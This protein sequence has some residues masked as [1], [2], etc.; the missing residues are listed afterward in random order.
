MDLLRAFER[1]RDL[2]AWKA[3]AQEGEG[4]GEGTGTAT[5]R[6]FLQHTLQHAQAL[7][8]ASERVL[9]TARTHSD[10]VLE[11]VL[12]AAVHCLENGR[13]D[14][15]KLVLRPFP[16][17][18]PLAAVLAWDAVAVSADADVLPARKQ[19]LRLLAE[20]PTVQLDAFDP[21]MLEAC[22]ELQ[23]RLYVAERLAVESRDFQQASDREL[24]FASL[25][26]EKLSRD[27]PLKVLLTDLPNLP[28]GLDPR[29][30]SEVL[31]A[32]PTASP[33]AAHALAHDH[34]VLHVWSVLKGAIEN[35]TALPDD[36]PAGG[37]G[38]AGAAEPFFVGLSRHL[39]EIRCSFL[40][41]WTLNALVAFLNMDR[42]SKF[43]Q[44]GGT[45][46]T[47]REYL[48]VIADRLPDDDAAGE[49]S[50]AQLVAS[51]GGAGA[52]GQSAEE[53]G[54]LL[55]A[56]NRATRVRIEAWLAEAQWR[57]KVIFELRRAPAFNLVSW[58][59]VMALLQCTPQML[60][61]ICEQQN[62]FELCERVAER[63]QLSQA[64]TAS[65][66]VSEWLQDM[67]SKSNVDD[68]ISQISSDHAETISLSDASTT[69]DDHGDEALSLDFVERL[70]LSP[71]R[72]AL[73]CLD[74]A[75]CAVGSRA[76]CQALAQKA[77]DYL[78]AF[79]GGKLGEGD[80][81]YHPRER[82][83]VFEARRTLQSLHEVL[84][85]DAE[86]G[87]PAPVSYRK[88]VTGIFP[89]RIHSSLE[90]TLPPAHVKA[91]AT[92]E[93]AVNAAAAGKRQFLSGL[94]HNLARALA[95]SSDV[96]PA[97]VWQQLEHLGYGP[98]RTL[99]TF[100][101]LPEGGAAAA[102]QGPEPLAH[103]YLTQFI[104]YLA[105]LGDILSIV[106]SAETFNHFSVLNRAPRNILLHIIFNRGQPESALQVAN[107]LGTDL[108]QE[109]LSA[110]VQPILP[111]GRAPAKEGAGGWEGFQGHKLKL[112]VLRYLAE[113][114]PVRV[115][116][117][118]TYVFIQVSAAPGWGVIPPSARRMGRG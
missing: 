56:V 74:I 36:P 39:G 50:V 87:P 106:D 64:D 62:N 72:K 86:G 112:D 75:T 14:A 76:S 88:A 90:A 49:S 108:V 28:N 96:A 116:L 110:C 78:D 8:S 43:T 69:T 58:N 97:T 19:I 85:E 33:K 18:Q 48:V 59:E 11:A 12:E 10:H 68:M 95:D 92:L 22:K 98:A 84:G 5:A 94:L 111:P 32:R 83:V 57:L 80:A 81:A 2:E 99:Q 109:V 118:C 115:A 41:L 52:E 54:A 73:L 23:Y 25:L 114:S 16:P 26:V 93:E 51:Q 104:S 44:K 91:V 60:L 4:E 21:F 107:L 71:L 27:S 9:H 55:A 17:L 45:A 35:L 38:A 29:A 15:A 13:L 82:A 66:Q 102:S 100:G 113:M 37:T 117:A 103:N 24:Y 101:G 42:P 105:K 79:V 47:V 40:R 46:E 31:N 89:D 63:F 30:A 77:K 6:L 7:S 20:S 34:N 1:G 53:V 70:N 65:M 61:N 67:I 3:G